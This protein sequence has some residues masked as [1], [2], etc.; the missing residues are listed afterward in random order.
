MHRCSMY[1][2]NTTQKEASIGSAVGM[3]NILAVLCI[4]NVGHDALGFS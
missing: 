4:S 2:L 1:I 3:Y